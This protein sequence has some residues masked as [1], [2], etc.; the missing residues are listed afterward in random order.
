MNFALDYPDRADALIMVGSAPV[1]FAYDDWSPSPL[2][3]EM[4]AAYQAGDLARVNDIAMRIFVDGKGRTSDQVDAALRQ[5]IYDMNMIALRN[6]GLLGRDVPP[7]VSAAQRIADL[8]T[9]TLVVIGDL[10]EE[11]IIRAADFMT[12]HI[13]HVQKIVMPGTAHLPN[14]EFPSEFNTHVQAFLNG[15]K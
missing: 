1:G 5:K 8:R 10:D 2:D 15:L 12:A 9:P 7:P 3:E 6:E 4:D 11:Y 13:P 14:V